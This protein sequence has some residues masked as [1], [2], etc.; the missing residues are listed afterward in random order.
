MAL[1][2]A[3]RGSKRP[4]QSIVWS[5]KDG[6]ALDLSGATIAGR[7]VD[8]AGT[9]RDCDGLFTIVDGPNGVFRWDYGDEDIGT[10]GKFA[11]QF[12]ATFGSSPTPARTFAEQW[13][14]HK[15][16]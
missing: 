8:S 2:S 13:Q 16:I 12:T 4:S 7:I 3:V 6:N 10:A 9:G 14:V 11:V 15:S 5:D 1:A